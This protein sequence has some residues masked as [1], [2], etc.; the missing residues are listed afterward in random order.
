VSNAQRSQFLEG[1]IRLAQRYMGLE[2]QSLNLQQQQIDF[3]NRMLHMNMII[4]G[5]QAAVGIGKAIGDLH[6]QKSTLAIQTGTT[7]YQQGVTEAITNGY[8][9]YK[10]ET[11]EN[12]QQ[13]RRY[14]GFDGYKMADGRT[15]GDL[16][17]EIINN[18]GNNYW[19]GGGAERGM[20]IAANAFE[21]IELGAQRQMA[22]EVIKNRQEA[23]NRRCQWPRPR[24]WTK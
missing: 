10:I 2:R 3:N 18:I 14:I 13:T 9:P 12:G 11:G 17:Q 24:A 15:L 20:Q 4:A 5:T 22:N 16:K 21:N 7:Q 23:F 6:D 19:T 1:D 8:N